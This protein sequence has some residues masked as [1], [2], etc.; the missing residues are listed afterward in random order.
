MEPDWTFEQTQL[1]EELKKTKRELERVDKEAEYA[2][3]E[4]E[5]TAR[6]LRTSLMEME[7]EHRK[8][9]ELNKE[10]EKANRIKSDFLATV[11]HELRTPLAS[12]KAFAEILLD[13]DI[14][15]VERMEF[16]EI[17]N[18]E[19]D[20]LGRLI[21]NLLT[22][23]RIESGQTHWEMK[24]I[25]MDKIIKFAVADMKLVI[26]KKGVEL[27]VKVMDNLPQVLCGDEDKLIEVLINLL[28][29]ALNFTGSGGKIEV[30][31]TEKK[32]NDQS[33][34]WISVSDT[35]VG[36]KPE[37]QEKIFDKFYQVK[38]DILTD[39]PTGSGLGLSICKEIVNHHSGRIWVESELEKGS[40]FNFTLPVKS[41]VGSRES[42]VGSRESGVGSNFGF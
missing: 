37:E 38:T 22:V 23:C 34:I 17:I 32:I 24:P 1:I 30:M 26:E 14:D 27:K 8:L 19:T 4:W 6:I 28:G 41:G 13:H 29:N 10:L 33:E 39:K 3:E 15:A 2:Y 12:I 36:I 25:S 5:K 9:E 16:L 35:G 42:G 31:A 18:S 20:R 7:N 40:S 21:N 11:S